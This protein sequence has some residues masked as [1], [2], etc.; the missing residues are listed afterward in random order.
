MV[1]VVIW[2]VINATDVVRATRHLV[3][4]LSINNFIVAHKYKNI[5]RVNTARR[6]IRHWARSKCTFVRIRY[7]ANVKYV[8]SV[9]VV[10]GFYK[11]TLE[12]IRERSPLSVTFVRAPLPIV[13]I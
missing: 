7:R 9:L 8:E 3:A 1:V 5:S 4:C 12:R 10:R 6:R 2:R 13:Q 11:V